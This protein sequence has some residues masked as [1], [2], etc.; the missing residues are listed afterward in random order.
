MQDST[1]EAVEK[2]IKRGKYPQDPDKTKADLQQEGLQKLC[3]IVTD[4]ENEHTPQEVCEAMGLDAS[5][6]VDYKL[7]E[8]FLQDLNG[9]DKKEFARLHAETFK[10]FKPKTIEITPNHLPLDE[11]SKMMD[12]ADKE[13]GREEMNRSSDAPDLTENEAPTKA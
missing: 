5:K 11:I 3:K 7:A 13:V 2:M 1:K 4:K 10:D 12:E 8:K 6:A 9:R